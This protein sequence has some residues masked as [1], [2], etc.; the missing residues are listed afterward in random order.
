M[1]FEKKQQILNKGDEV[2]LVSNSDGTQKMELVIKQDKKTPVKRTVGTDTVNNKVEAIPFL[3]LKRSLALYEENELIIFRD[4]VFTTNK[5]EMIEKLR[6]HQ[7]FGEQFFEKDYPKD[8]QDQLD[9]DRKYL[10]KE[11]DPETE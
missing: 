3:S 6:N 5:P 2:K 7:L 9:C 10:T 4:Y 8:V 1:P 11:K